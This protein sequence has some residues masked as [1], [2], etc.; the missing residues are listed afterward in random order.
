M[1]TESRSDTAVAAARSAGAGRT[2][3][4]EAAAEKAVQQALDKP[5]PVFNTH[6]QGLAGLLAAQARSIQ[7]KMADVRAKIAEL[8][9]EE[10]DLMRAESAIVKASDALVVDQ[11]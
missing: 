10:T 2:L 1:T 4:A 5:G 8:H 7:E 9:A 3:P 11:S 6:S